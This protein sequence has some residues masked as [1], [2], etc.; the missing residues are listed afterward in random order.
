ML[1]AGDVRQYVAKVVLSFF[2]VYSLHLPRGFEKLRIPGVRNEIWGV[3]T[4]TL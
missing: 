2:E 1:V 4:H 3:L